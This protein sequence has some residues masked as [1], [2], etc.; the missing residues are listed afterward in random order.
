VTLTFEKAGEVT[1]PITVA[2]PGEESRGESFD[3]HQ[4]EA[5]TEG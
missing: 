3:F 1:L 5:T 4:D 2:N